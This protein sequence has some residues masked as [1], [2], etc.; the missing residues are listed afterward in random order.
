M[1]STSTSG[2]EEVKKAA[3]AAE[4]GPGRKTTPEFQKR[5]FLI[6]IDNKTVKGQFLKENYGSKTSSKKQTKLTILED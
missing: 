6:G 3:G 5:Q 1:A 4:C 2:R